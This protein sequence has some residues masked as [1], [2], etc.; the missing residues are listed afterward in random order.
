MSASAKI[1]GTLTF[2]FPSHGSAQVMSSQHRQPISP[3]QKMDFAKAVDI[4]RRQLVV[5]RTELGRLLDEPLPSALA[6]YPHLPSRVY[7]LVPQAMHS[8]GIQLVDELGIAPIGAAAAD[9]GLGLCRTYVELDTCEAEEANLDSS[10]VLTIDYTRTALT[11]TFSSF[12]ASRNAYDWDESRAWDLD[13]GAVQHGDEG[14]V[15]RYWRRVRTEIQE[16]YRARLP[17]CM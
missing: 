5:L 9:H 3:A 7:G 6:S 16:T 1:G 17:R 15:E 13:A 8:A 4:L 11:V 2:N 12:K 14:L 10:N